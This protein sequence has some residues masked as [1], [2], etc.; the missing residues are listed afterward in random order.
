MILCMVQ[1]RQKMEARLE[2]LERAY[3]NYMKTRDEVQEMRH[4]LETAKI[5]ESR[6]CTKQ[7]AICP[8][9]THHLAGYTGH[10]IKQ[11]PAVIIASNRGHKWNVGENC[12]FQFSMAMTGLDQ[13]GGTL[14]RFKRSFG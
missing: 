6:S 7:F 5:D 11:N 1:T 14:F 4:Q 9:R 3:Q 8:L 2:F 10:I 13:P 12:R